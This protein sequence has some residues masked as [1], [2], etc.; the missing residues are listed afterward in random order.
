[1]K[2]K[3]GERIKSFALTKKEPPLIVLFQQVGMQD[4]TLGCGLAERLV[5]DSQYFPPL[6]VLEQGSQQF[7]VG[8][9]LIV[10]KLY[11]GHVAVIQREGLA[12][13]ERQLRDKLEGWH[14]FKTPED[15]QRG[16]ELS[17][18]GGINW[19]FMDREIGICITVIQA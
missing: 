3:V 6:D 1:I 13:L 11:R 4:I 17:G 10:V 19:L 7:Q 9:I 14:A 2:R 12:Q 18:F 15:F 5:F 8:E 16:F